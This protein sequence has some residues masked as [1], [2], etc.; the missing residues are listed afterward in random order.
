MAMASLNPDGEIVTRPGEKRSM[1]LGSAMNIA[2]ATK[3]KIAE[4]TA[5]Y[6][7]TVAVKELHLRMIETGNHEDAEEYHQWRDVLS[8][9]DALMNKGREL[10]R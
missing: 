2:D 5:L 7:C 3:L 4:S 9:L 10:I 8:K 1:E 6:G